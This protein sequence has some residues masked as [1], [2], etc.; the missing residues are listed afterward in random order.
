LFFFWG[1]PLP[2][3]DF[4]CSPH[5]TAATPNCATAAYPVVEMGIQLPDEALGAVVGVLIFS[6]ICLLCTCIM[7]WLIWTHHERDSCKYT[8]I[9]ARVNVG[10]LTCIVVGLLAYFTFLSTVTSIIQQLHTMIWWNDVKTEQW[11]NLRAHA[12]S[13]EIAIAGPSVGLDLVLFYI[14][15]SA[16]QLLLVVKLTGSK[17]ISHTMLKQCSPFSGLARS[18]SPSSALRTW[19][20]SNVSAIG[21]TLP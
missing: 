10:V 21:P 20:R 6:I 3:F 19:H 18:P 14:R 4:T 8:G 7:I 12:G 11:E 16:A 2:V 1:G 15:A 5:N 17:N 13:V 9:A